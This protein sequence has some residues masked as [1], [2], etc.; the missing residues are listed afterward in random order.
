MFPAFS[1]S[2]ESYEFMKSD[3]FLFYRTI[4]SHIKRDKVR[5]EAASKKALS[6]VVPHTQKKENE[7]WPTILLRVVIALK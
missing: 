2:C 6:K 4:E 1:W 5:K 7:D 3:F